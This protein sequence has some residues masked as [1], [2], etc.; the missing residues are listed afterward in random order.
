MPVVRYRA[1][2]Q[3]G[4]APL[5]GVRRRAA[6]TAE[7]L[8]AGV[9]REK[10]RTFEVAARVGQQV[11]GEAFNVAQQVVV[12][13]RETADRV[14]RLDWNNRLA[15]WEQDRIED[16][17]H[18]AYTRMGKD[19]QGLPE[20]LDKDFADFTGK[21][22][23]G[24]NE[25]QRLQF[26]EDRARR[27]ESID[28]SV[29]RHMRQQQKAYA[30]SELQAT[31]TNAVNEAITNALDPDRVNIALTRA[32]SA[33]RDV[34]PSLGMGKEEIEALVKSDQ[35][36]AL[37][38]VINR[39]LASDN[40]AAAQ[41]YF[42]DAK[43]AGLISGE[44]IANI[45]KKLA[46]GTTRKKAQ[47]EA[48]KIIAAGGSLTEQLAKAKEFG[49]DDPDL[50]KAIEERI[51]H[52]KA[53]MDREQRDTHEAE[54][55]RIYDAIDKGTTS[56]DA[57]ER[58]PEWSNLEGTERASVKA[59]LRTKIGGG[60][61]TDWKV[62][63]ERMNEAGTDPQA[64]AKRNL[65]AD[66][67]SLEDTEWKRLMEIQL[68]IRAGDNRKADQ[69]LDVYRTT[70]Q[71]VN[72]TVGLDPNAPPSSDEAK[73][74]GRLR[75]V[76]ERRVLEAEQLTGKKVPAA[77]IQTWLD[78]LLKVQLTTIQGTG[79]NWSLIPGGT[80]KDSTR[81]S[82]IDL[83]IGDIPA[84][85]QQQ[86]KDALRQRGRLVNDDAVLDLYIAN[87]LRRGQ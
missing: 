84:A 29:R 73:A 81:K 30:T 21:I 40:P 83:R 38:G 47:D 44:A 45:E 82:I 18:G 43:Q 71:I 85:E 87:K 65:L 51:E 55:R 61:V 80:Q 3:V 22:G 39:L 37:T 67:G 53:V 58:M 26:E 70:S 23:E 56:L 31:R 62:F 32:V 8:G 66:R 68:S 9:A 16:P 72:G 35:S 28:L 42:Q 27:K 69:D 48:D 12:K 49:K 7:S 64:F 20:E 14:A 50:R 54:G 15:E 25:R 86:L 17:E 36:Q 10:E 4:T 46:E 33:I 5:P 77:D 13:E 24:L 60:Q 57:I 74:V 1:E 59:Y 76:L 63:G 2:R 41:V 52:S 79:S 78:D 34:G 75:A 6:D 19:A 11:A